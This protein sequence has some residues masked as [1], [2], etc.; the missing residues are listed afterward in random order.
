M[1]GAPGALPVPLGTLSTCV[2]TGAGAGEVAEAEFSV[3]WI[4]LVA[5]LT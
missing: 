3:S 1:H 2:V 4:D 5:A